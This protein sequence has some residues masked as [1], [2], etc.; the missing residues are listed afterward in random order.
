MHTAGTDVHQSRVGGCIGEE[1]LQDIQ[2]PAHVDA[3]TSH[4]LIEIAGCE[5]CDVRQVAR[6]GYQYID[7]S[8]T[9]LGGGEGGVDGRRVDDVRDVSEHLDARMFGLDVLLGGF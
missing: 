7:G 9:V 6:V 4:E 1:R 3:E 2:V 8:E 5:R